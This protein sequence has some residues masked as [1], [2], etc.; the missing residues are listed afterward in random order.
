MK[1]ERW[2]STLYLQLFGPDCFTTISQLFIQGKGGGANVQL[3]IHYVT[4][5][6][7]TTL[8]EIVHYQKKMVLYKEGEG[9]RDTEKYSFSIIDNIVIQ[10]AAFPIFC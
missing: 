3:K 2:N 8:T 6:V 4:L 10:I 9:E 7:K 1:R 5:H